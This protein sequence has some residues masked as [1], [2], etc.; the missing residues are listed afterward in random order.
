[1][2]KNIFDIKAYLDS[3]DIPYK[4]KGENVT[5]G[6]IEICCILPGC[7]DHKEHLGINLKTLIYKCW[8]CGNKGHALHLIEIIEQCSEGVARHIAKKF[9]HDD[10]DSIWLE[11]EESTTKKN[12]AGVTLPQEIVN[13]W[14]Q[15]HFD[16]LKSRK[17]DPEFIIPKYDLK[18][19]H[20]VGRY[21]FRVI[22]P[23][24]YDKKL[25]SFTSMDVLRDGNRPP[26]M[27][28]PIDES[29]IPVKECL[30][31]ID[32]VPIGGKAVIYEGVTGVWRFGDGAVASFTS[33]LTQEQIVMLVRKRL[34]E[35][36]IIYDP[37]AKKKGQNMAT[38]LSGVI[39]S[40]QQ[41]C[42]EKGDPKDLSRSEIIQLKKDLRFI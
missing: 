2:T 23:I 14:P 36:F 40:V 20:T 1:M 15:I 12:F 26:Y 37:D 3:K 21:R 24:Y 34:K 8:L 39:P 27:D 41:I 30:Y 31:N 38:Q 19:V 18:P 42:F 4:T 9:P 32:N 22:I 13:E 35:V 28:C 5:R 10:D 17:F 33:N 29:I 25:V 7:S 6:W 11:Q 16:Y